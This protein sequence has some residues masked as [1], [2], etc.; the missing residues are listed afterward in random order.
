[1]EATDTKNVS[2]QSQE[3][4]SL[5]SVKANVD[6]MV[7]INCAQT[8]K[9]QS[10]VVDACIWLSTQAKLIRFV[11]N[12]HIIHFPSLITCRPSLLS[13]ACPDRAHGFKRKRGVRLRRGRPSSSGVPWQHACMH[14]HTHMHMCMQKHKNIRHTWSKETVGETKEV[15]YKNDP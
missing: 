10:Q 9:T 14:T 11:L 12:N 13:V 6:V 3:T 7:N 2:T 1:M 15:R 4:V 8:F 5:S